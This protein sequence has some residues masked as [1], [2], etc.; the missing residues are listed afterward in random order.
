MNK[1]V[2]WIL[3]KDIFPAGF[4]AMKNSIAMA[5]HEF[6]VWE[7]HWGVKNRNALA[8]STVV[9]HGSLN[10]ASQIASSKIWNPG[11]FC[12]TSKFCCSSW[13]EEAA[14]WL[15]NKH[16]R[17][18][19][20][21]ELVSSNKDELLNSIGCV[22]SVFVRPNSP[23]K[24]FSGRVLKY[25]NITLRALDHGYYYDD[26]SL[27]CVIA[28]VRQISNEWRYVVVNGCVVAGSA[29]DAKSKTNCQPDDPSGAPWHFAADIAATL[30]APEDVY[31]LDI[32]ESDGQLFLLELNPFSGADLYACNTDSVV[33]AV[34]LAASRIR[35]HQ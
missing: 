18:T 14:P 13:C 16:W 4:E 29:Y 33:N 32:C 21:K 22:G 2:T 11:A 1:S 35:W 3:E 27:E 30:N 12:N 10:I 15:L 20:I 6:I 5:G 26:E 8:A 9:F 19:T 7:S 34:S 28:P 23:L 24:P 17:L 25:N 31:V